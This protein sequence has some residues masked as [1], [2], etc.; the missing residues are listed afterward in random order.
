MW[1]RSAGVLPCFANG[2]VAVADQ[3]SC[4][5]SRRAA[6]GRVDRCLPDG[7]RNDNQWSAIAPWTHCSNWTGR[8]WSSTR[9]PGRVRFAV[10]R[11]PASEAKPHGPDYSLTLHGP[12]GERL[13][14]FDNA[15]AVRG[16]SGP[17]G[18]P[19]STFDHQHGLK[20]VRPYEYK[21]AASLLA[22]FWSAVDAVLRGKG[23]M[24]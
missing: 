6:T 3:Y 23:I 16:H 11:V 9:R 12:N 1:W 17:G 21:D 15:H 24:L 4:H 10:H 7:I 20:T 22:D 2:A 19:G 14:G 18:R 8:C 5:G 13:V